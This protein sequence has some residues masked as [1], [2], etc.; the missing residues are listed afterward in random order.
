MTGKWR[1][2]ALVQIGFAVA[3]SLIIILVVVASRYGETGIDESDGVRRVQTDGEHCSAVL[4]DDWDWR[5]ASWTAISPHGTQMGFSETLHGRPE[6]PEWEE[7]AD[8]IL[9]RYEDRD[10]VTVSVDEDLIRM[11]FGESGGLSVIQ[12]F[13]RV[14]CRLTFSG[15]GD[16]REQELPVWEEIIDSLTRTSPTGTPQEDLPWKTT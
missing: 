15:G 7:S 5:P 11:D 4:P 3:V 10:D 2:H 6:Y 16:N 8:E 14:G 12:R 9:E 13:D 1:N